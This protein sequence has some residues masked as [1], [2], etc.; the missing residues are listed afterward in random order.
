[1]WDNGLGNGLTPE[2]GVYSHSNGTSEEQS[3]FHYKTSY[4]SADLRLRWEFV[5]F[6]D[7]SP[8]LL[9][10]VGITSFDASRE[11]KVYDPTRERGKSNGVAVSFPVAL[12]IKYSITPKLALDL[13]GGQYM[14]LTDDLNPP[15][16]GINDNVW[17]AKLGISYQI[18]T[19]TDAKPDSDGDGLTDEDEVALGTDP[20]NPDT[21]GDGLLDGEEVLTYKTDPK[22]PDTDFGGV[23]DGIEVRN[24]ANPLDAEDDILN[25]Q[26]G[27]KII[28]RNIEFVTGK[29]EIT[30][31]SQ[32]ILSNVVKA[33]NKLGTMEFDIVGH[34]DD[35]GDPEKNLKLSEARANSVKEWLVQR[36][37]DAARLTP[38]G[39]G[40]TEPLVPN[41]SDENRQKNRRVEFFRSK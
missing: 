33:M 26:V 32:K 25:I 17:F 9:G 20:N 22:N 34:T 14:S 27:E 38:M 30:E 15:H 23:K 41:T 29:S 24:G 8:Y 4:L 36:G 39:K 1:M 37:I 28:L 31:R 19:F 7:F 40:Q 6:G 10:G 13:N 2:L 3:A 12:G 21:D 18:V 35:V 16:D 5:R 11:D